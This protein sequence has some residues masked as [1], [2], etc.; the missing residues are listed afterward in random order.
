MNCAS[1]SNVAEPILI[2]DDPQNETYTTTNN[3]ET[4]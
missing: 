1:N 2:P 3:L 4:Q